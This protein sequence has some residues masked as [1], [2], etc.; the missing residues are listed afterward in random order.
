[1]DRVDIITGT[2][3]KAL[4]GA[5]RRL[6]QRP[7]GD[8]RAAAPA[9]APVPVLQHARAA[10]RRRLAEGARAA[11]ERRRAARAA[12]R[13]HGALP[14]AHDRAGLRRPARRPPDRA[15]HVRRRGPRRP[16]RRGDARARDLRDRVLLP[17]RPARARRGSARRCRPRTRRTTSTARSPPSRPCAAKPPSTHS[18][19]REDGRSPRCAPAPCRVQPPSMTRH[20]PRTP[21]SRPEVPSPRRAG[22]QG[23][24]AQPSGPRP[25]T[26]PPGQRTPLTSSGGVRSQRGLVEL[27]LLL[28]PEG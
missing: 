18:A 7:R 6:H 14:H 17:G 3:G 28:R 22:L 11:R 12:A 25:R 2:L 10:D 15:D 20:G 21:N 4:G 26:S 23:E 9:L 27:S 1:M 8:R 13:Q 19:R 16:H 5:S 24:P